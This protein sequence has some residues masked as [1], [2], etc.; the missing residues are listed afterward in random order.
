MKGITHLCAVALL[1]VA[2]PMAAAQSSTEKAP[3]APAPE[4]E[5]PENEPARSD[6]TDSEFKREV[7]E[8]VDAIRAYSE[9]RRDEAVANARRAAEDLDL[10]MAGLQ[11]TMDQR[12]IQ[13]SEKAR[14]RSQA[15]MANLRQRRNALAEWYGGMRHSSSAAWSDVKGGFVRSYHE[16]ADAMREARAEFEQE[17]EESKDPAADDPARE[18]HP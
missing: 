4:T 7:D 8:R 16:L 13:M 14:T 18:D 9:E 15:T 1:V 6:P 17:D 3:P 5:Q 12:W 2:I 11:Q 10:K